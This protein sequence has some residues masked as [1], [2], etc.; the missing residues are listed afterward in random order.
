MMELNKE[1]RMKETEVK[2]V[3]GELAD[4]ELDNVSGGCSTRYVY[5]ERTEIRSADPHCADCGERLVFLPDGQHEVELDGRV[6]MCDEFMCGNVRCGTNRVL[7]LTFLHVW[8]GDRWFTK[9][10]PAF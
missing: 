8:E 6:Y 9:R 7:G 10:A 4:E 2:A 3:E 1:Q 5:N